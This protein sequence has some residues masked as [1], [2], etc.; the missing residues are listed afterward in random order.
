MPTATH[1]RVLF[2]FRI[3]GKEH[4]LWNDV[5]A[6]CVD[7]KFRRG[8]LRDTTVNQTRCDTS[9]I[10]SNECLCKASS[11]KQYEEQSCAC[12][13]TRLL[14]SLWFLGASR[15]STFTCFFT[16]SKEGLD[17]CSLEHGVR[18]LNFLT[19]QERR[20]VDLACRE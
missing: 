18:P 9:P 16:A 7:C 14:A 6:F 12:L 19:R 5:S 2:G 17:G 3:H 4:S 8:I 1:L 13:L 15:M 11:E 10:V 20:N